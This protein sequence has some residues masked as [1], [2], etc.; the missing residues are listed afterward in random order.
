[1]YQIPITIIKI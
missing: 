1:M